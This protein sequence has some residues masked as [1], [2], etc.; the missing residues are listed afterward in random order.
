MT[1]CTA[2]HLRVNVEKTKVVVFGARAYTPPPPPRAHPWHYA[3]RPVPLEPSFRYLGV[4][5]HSTRGVGPAVQHVRAAGLRALWGMLARCKTMGIV[6]F[7][8][9]TRLYR[10]LVEPILTYGAGVWGPD[11]MPTTQAGLAAPLQV[12]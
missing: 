6:D 10:A 8:L 12:L 1:F 11:L 5:M 7:A 2:N 4:V 3:G 9:R